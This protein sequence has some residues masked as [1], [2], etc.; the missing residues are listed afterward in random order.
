MRMSI[1]PTSLAGIRVAALVDADGARGRREVSTLFFAGDRLAATP[2]HSHDGD[3][4]LDVVAR[5]N[6]PSP[7]AVPGLI[8][9]HAHM[10]LGGLRLAQLD[11]SQVTSR[12]AFE[13]AVAMHHAT[14]PPEM[15]LEGW[16]WSEQNWFGAAPPDKSWLAACGDRPAI[17]WRMDHHACVVND[18]VLRLLGDA[19]DPS[20][21]RIVRSADG[22]PTGLFV[23]SAAWS[24]IKPLAPPPSIEARQR[25][26]RAALVE[27]NRF[28]VTCVGSME[29]GEDLEDV[30]APLRDELTLRVRITMLDRTEPVDT[31]RALRF[32]SD[33]RLAVI[34]C[35]AF[36]DGTLG[37]RTALM[38]E[39]YADDPA[40]SG[41]V[42][43]HTGGE[44]LDNWIDAVAAAGLSPSMHAIGDAAVRRALDAADRVSARVRPRIEHAQTVHPE[45]I[46]RFR[47]RISSMQPLHK[48][49]D[50]RYAERRLGR[51][52]MERFFPFRRLLEAGA[53]LA[54][55]SDWPIVTCDPIAGMRAAIT[56]LDLDGRPVR[57]DQSL[58]PME[59]LAAYTAGAAAALGIRDAGSLEPGRRADVTILSHDPLTA[60]W[61]ANP[62]RVLATIVGGRLV[63]AAPVAAPTTGRG[64]DE[65]TSMAPAWSVT[66]SPER[67]GIHSG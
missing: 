51:E 16:G 42:I 38:L 62:P 60:D 37:S 11:L 25:A 41:L 1:D 7:V 19:A 26:L 57:V 4:V 29:Y 44:G 20:G 65:P 33:D 36:L 17:C 55:G 49:D 14:L 58:T 34:G 53:V 10:L 12:A 22:A 50:G 67:G 28:G 66:G 27:L 56:G 64:V 3:S 48:A 45:D 23:E 39:P 40:N 31:A 61:V 52:R 13:Q 46:P 6:A 24:L 63:Y 5:W 32:R 54:F 35:K 8:D 30:F 15:W 18:A 59:A 43:E 47:G 21:G 9:A 2:G